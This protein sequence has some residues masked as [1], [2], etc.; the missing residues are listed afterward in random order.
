MMTLTL[1]SMTCSAQGSLSS[2][3][4]PGNMD[5][6]VKPVD[7]FYQYACGGW[8]TKNPLPAAYSRFGSFDMIGEENNKRVNGILDELLKGNYKKGSIEQKLS[9]LY[10]FAMDAERRNKEGV[11]PAM[12]LIEQLEKA[13]T[14]A[15]L[16][17][18]QLS[19]APYGDSE[20][21]N[22]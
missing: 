1:M 18:V 19:M 22:A 13:K 9:D 21:F 12:A 11:T 4:D 10:K 17:Q 16:F 15:Q 7:D 2:G 5:K 20:F 3:I 14:V 8:M 6:S